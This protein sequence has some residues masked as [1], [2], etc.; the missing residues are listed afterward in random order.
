MTKTWTVILNNHTAFEQVGVS[1]KDALG[2]ATRRALAIGAKI[3][4][5]EYRKLRPHR[6]LAGYG[7]C[8]ICGQKATSSRFIASDC[9]GKWDC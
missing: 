2:R 6:G 3:K 8:V 4:S 7:Y 9:V 5:F 1:R